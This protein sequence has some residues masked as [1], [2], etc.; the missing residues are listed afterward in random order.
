M[1]RIVSIV[2]VIS[3]S[4][5]PLSSTADVR[6]RAS[7]L[8][9]QQSINLTIYNGGSALIHDQRRVFLTTGLN[10]IAWRDVSANM[11]PASATVD[12]SGSSSRISVLEQN[13]D[14]DVLDQDS[15]LHKYV[16]Q[17]VTVVHP[18]RFAGERDTREPARILSV[19]PN[20]V[21]QYHDRIE[22]QLNGYI[23]F[24]SVPRSLRDRPTLTLDVQSEQSG[25]HQLDL[26]YLTSGLSWH[27]D[28]IGTLNS[29][30]SVMSLTGLVTLENTSGTSYRDARLQLV[31]GNVNVAQARGALKTI[32]NVTASESA[33]FYRTNAAQENY[34]EYH[35][36]TLAHRTTILDKQT[37]QLALLSAS[38]VPVKKTLELRG[39]PSY[40]EGANADLGDRLP[41]EVYAS[42]ANRGGD[43][44]IPLPAGTMRIYQNDSRGLAQFLGSDNIGH[45]P[46]NDTV[47]LYLGNAFDL[48]ARRRQ[49]DFHLISD[50][51]ATSTYEID[52]INGKDVAQD[53]LVVEQIPGDW[54]ISNE[55][56]KHLKSSATTATW[57]VRVPQDAQA[58]LT[59]TADVTWC[60]H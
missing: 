38:E 30:Q 28:Y 53:V 32:S 1:K 36:Y 4:V 20:V 23:A 26:R 29:D 9:D 3:M 50:C 40:Y 18:A 35:L 5:T 55:S 45:T 54:T 46:K 21:L 14:Y 17:M 12:S 19:D 31:A 48:V 41:I 47:R 8:A 33:D 43:L 13:F 44:G 51:Q 57:T 10:R 2:F 39:S 25:T 56:Q 37:K 7:T 22:T 16:G 60:R 49:T 15:L 34:F 42:F 24:P 58:A 52:F 59:Y 11:E 6:E 27:V